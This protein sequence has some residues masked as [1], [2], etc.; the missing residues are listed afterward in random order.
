MASFH[1]L[2]SELIS[3]YLYVDGTASSITERA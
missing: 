2:N 1:I 3:A